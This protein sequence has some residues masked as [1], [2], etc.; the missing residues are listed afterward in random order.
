MR[1]THLTPEQRAAAEAARAQRQT[2]Y[3]A[4]TA[5]EEAVERL[6]PKRRHRAKH[7]LLERKDVPDAE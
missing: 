6:T 4:A 3:E 5:A 7:A 1:I 2:E